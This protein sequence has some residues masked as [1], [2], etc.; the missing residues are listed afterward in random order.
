VIK[1]FISGL[2]LSPLSATFKLQRIIGVV[3]TIVATLAIGIA[4][5][6]ATTSGG[7]ALYISGP[8]VQGAE[9]D[10]VGTLTENFNGLGGSPSSAG[11]TC[12]TALAVGTLSIA[13][14]TSACQY[15][16]PGIWGGAASTTSSPFFG[17]SGSNY[18]GTYSNSNAALTFT[19]PAG[20]VKYVG[21]WWSGGNRGNVV[22]FYNG[23]TEIASLDTLDLETLLGANPPSSWPS[24]N[25]SVTSMGGTAYPKGHY[26]GNPRGYAEYPPQ[27]QAAAV[28]QDGVN[29]TEHRG[30]V[31]SYLNLFLTGDQTATSVK[32]SGNGFEFDNLTTSTLEQTP[33]PSLVFA[34]G[35]IGKSVQFLSGANDATGSM[36]AQASTAAANLSAN[37]FQ[38]T[39]YTFTGWNTAQNGSG[40]PYAA[41][42]NFSFA[43]DLTL[44]AQWELTPTPTPTPTPTT[45]PTSTSTPA[46]SPVSS[47]GSTSPSGS[48]AATQLAATGFDYSLGLLAAAGTISLGIF[49]IAMAFAVR[50]RSRSF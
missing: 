37:R 8:L 38:R 17:G 2:W 29:Y 21:F 30:Y 39:G 50:R 6:S 36:V 31:F 22:T 15:R 19:F 7:I 12:P 34:K 48:L 24:G 18:F 9:I 26:F 47:P 14:S 4:P 23:A 44:Y 27:S 13:P 42:A 25:G 41:G 40:T 46:A 33:A 49:S 43:S 28:N 32:F 16:T 11:G 1:N 20:G 45:T 35:L 3:T 5:A 10:S